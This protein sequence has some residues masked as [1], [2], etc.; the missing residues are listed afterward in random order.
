MENGIISNQRVKFRD[1]LPGRTY[2]CHGV[3]QM[4]VEI[5]EGVISVQLENGTYDKDVD[6]D[7]WVELDEVMFTRKAK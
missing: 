1:L 4:K 5:E 7:T 3:Y 2:L 6:L